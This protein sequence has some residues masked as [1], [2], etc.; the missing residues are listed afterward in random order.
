[1]DYLNPGYALAV[2]ALALALAAAIA[3][4]SAWYGERLAE[5]AGNRFEM[6]DGLRGFLAFGVLLSHVVNNHTYY[7]TGVWSSASG[8]YAMSGQAGVSLFFM[9]TGFLF[10]SRVL[11]S[12][13]AFDARAL[14]L[15]RL[16]R[17]V[18]MYAVSV[19]FVF[20]IVAAVSGFTLHEPLVSLARE[21]RAWL[22]FG[23]LDGGEINGVKEAHIINATYWTLAY[24]WL[25]YLS[26]PLLALYARGPRFLLLVLAVVFFGM[27]RPI[28][29]NF[30]CGALAALAVEKRLL[31]GRLASRW[32]APVPLAALALTFAF[33]SAYAPAPIALLFVFFLFVVD[34]NDLL[35]LLRLPAAKL[36]GM[37]SYS[38]YLLHCMVLYVI[39]RAFDA[40]LPVA[41]LGPAQYWALAALAGLATVALSA[42]TYRYVEYPFHALRPLA[43]ASRIDVLGTAGRVLS[44]S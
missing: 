19:A 1:M 6:I 44:R 27:Q 5:A 20:A 13:E 24:E 8:F 30:L 15:S 33:E 16:R 7:T 40:F 23:F 37:V 38:V 3:R 22:S 26:L 42:L 10:W 18:P 11:K 21:A 41:L 9:I 39:Y 2:M 34:G 12:A 25:F 28:T 14:F 17:L 29:F 31:E 35:G 36:L 4:S 43:K 32:L